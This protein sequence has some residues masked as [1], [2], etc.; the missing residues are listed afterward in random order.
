MSSPSK[1]Q[2]E[3]PRPVSRRFRFVRSRMVS[4]AL[5]FLCKG[6]SAFQNFSVFRKAETQVSPPALNRSLYNSTNRCSSVAVIS[7]KLST[8][9]EASALSKEYPSLKWASMSCFS[10]SKYTTSPTPC[11][12]CKRVVDP[13]MRHGRMGDEFLSMELRLAGASPLG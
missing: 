12:S 7:P 4:A 1:S 2:S 9:L 3:I 6:V 5:A 10:G 8:A 11:L 13:Q